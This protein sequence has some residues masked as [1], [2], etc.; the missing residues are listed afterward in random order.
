MLAGSAINYNSPHPRNSD[1]EALQALETL[2]LPSPSPSFETSTSYTDTGEI[3]I[4]L[5]TGNELSELEFE[6]D[7]SFVLL[8]SPY[9]PSSRSNSREPLLGTPSMADISPSISIQPDPLSPL[10]TEVLG[11]FQ[12]TNARTMYKYSSNVSPYLASPS[13]TFSEQSRLGSPTDFRFTSPLGSP[14]MSPAPS[15]RAFSQGSSS[16]T[17]LSSTSIYIP[18][19]PTTPDSIAG[20]RDSLSP[21]RCTSIPSQSYY[22]RHS[23]SSRSSNTVSPSPSIMMHDVDESPLMS[24][25]STLRSDMRAAT[26]TPMNMSPHNNHSEGR[27]RTESIMTSN[28]F[29][30][31]RSVHSPR[32]IREPGP[33]GSPSRVRNLPA[34]LEWLRDTKIELCIDQ[35]GFR[36]ARPCFALSSF[37]AGTYDPS[38][39]MTRA[40][41]V[42]GSADFRPTTREL[43]LFHHGSLDPQPI[44]RRLT[45]AGDESKD[46]ISRQA[47]LTLRANGVYAVNGVETLDFTPSADRRTW[48]RDH[49]KLR[50]KFEYLVEDRRSD[51]TGK[52]L[53]GEKT[54]RPLSF[55]CSPG[56]LHPNQ[57]KKIRFTQVFKKGLTPKLAAE[58]TEIPRPP[59]RDRT[60]S[61]REDNANKENIPPSPTLSLSERHA[62]L[63]PPLKQRKAQSMLFPLSP[64]PRTASHLT[65][66]SLSSRSRPIVRRLMKPSMTGST[67]AGASPGCDPSNSAGSNAEHRMAAYDVTA[68]EEERIFVADTGSATTQDAGWLRGRR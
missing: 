25:T 40:S 13:V 53:S 33:L 29:L 38:Y 34:G 18:Q 62:S 58:R 39:S 63:A 11:Q 55:T 23:A 17:L 30:S 54:F 68:E 46:F 61:A 8:N 9:H 31:A 64:S 67:L 2:E 57:G 41:C 16:G 49:S 10:S 20:N 50:W 5:D 32:S 6:E 14:H 22:M 36:A 42:Q 56:L 28:S 19:Q 12:T 48:S 27:A 21:Y 4:F 24:R 60:R 45:L 3:P 43:F 65:V 51:A 37:T 47:V 26:S 52:I 7:G 66:Q 15:S 44:L 59:I 35:E 1:W